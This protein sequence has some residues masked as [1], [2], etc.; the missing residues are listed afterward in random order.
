MASVEMMMKVIGE[1]E[2]RPCIVDGKEALFHCWQERTRIVPPSPMVGGHG[3]GVLKWTVGIFEDRSGRVFELNQENHEII[4]IDNLMNDEENI[5]CFKLYKLK[6][7]EDNE[8]E[9]R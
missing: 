6:Q 8:N 4:F 5:D 7:R 3:G 2:K 1:M 9:E